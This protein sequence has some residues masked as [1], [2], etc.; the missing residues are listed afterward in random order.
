M[1]KL[2]QAVLSLWGKIPRKVKYVA[3][4]LALAAVKAK[5]PDLPLAVDAKWLAAGGAGL[6]IAHTL[7]DVAHLLGAKDIDLG[8]LAAE[9]L[10]AVKLAPIAAGVP[11]DPHPASI[12]VRPA[13]CSNCGAAIPR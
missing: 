6:A 5:W 12:T 11:A 10:Q 13:A 9:V 1:E 2:Q 8:K 7:T 3:A 4:G